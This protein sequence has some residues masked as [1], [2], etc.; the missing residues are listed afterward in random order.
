MKSQFGSRSKSAS[1]INGKNSTCSIWRHKNS[2]RPQMIRTRFRNSLICSTLTS[3]RSC[4]ANIWKGSRLRRWRVNSWSI[5]LRVAT[6]SMTTS[7]SSTWWRLCR[8]TIYLASCLPEKFKITSITTRRESRTLSMSCETR[9]WCRKRCSGDWWNTSNATT[10]GCRRGRDRSSQRSMIRISR[11]ASSVRKCRS[12]CLPSSLSTWATSRRN[13]DSVGPWPFCRTCAPLRS[14]KTI[15]VTLSSIIRWQWPSWSRKIRKICWRTFSLTS[16][17]KF[18]SLRSWS[19]M[20]VF[21]CPG[22]NSRCRCRCPR[23]RY[24]WS[25]LRSHRTA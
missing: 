21:R 7:R 3:A 16:V 15:C 18:S 25:Q 2:S 13:S 24:R 8:P 20:P 10:N 12:L 6:T 5:S 4:R 17:C 1:I 22:S 23:S 19:P 9:S 14:R 11:A